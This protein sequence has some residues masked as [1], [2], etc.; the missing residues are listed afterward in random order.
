MLK[1]G[2]FAKY[3]QQDFRMAMGKPTVFYSSPF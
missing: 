2:T 3:T 1:V